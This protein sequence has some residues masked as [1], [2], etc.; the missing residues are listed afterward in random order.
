MSSPAR[1]GEMCVRV[2]LSKA[3]CSCVAEKYKSVKDA[4]YKKGVIQHAACMIAAPRKKNLDEVSDAD[5]AITI[6]GVHWVA[7]A[8]RHVRS[9]VKYF[10]QIASDRP[11]MDVE[12]RDGKAFPSDE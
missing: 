6:R 5:E 11:T 7:Y 3:P 8:G 4:R 1:C 9:A 10:N 2:S 12:L